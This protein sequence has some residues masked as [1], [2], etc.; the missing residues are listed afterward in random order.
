MKNQLLLLLYP[1]LEGLVA[2]EG[3]EMLHVLP[4]QLEFRR[5]AVELL[6]RPPSHLAKRQHSNLNEDHIGQQCCD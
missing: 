2:L 1:N 6:D 5:P 4:L 3:V